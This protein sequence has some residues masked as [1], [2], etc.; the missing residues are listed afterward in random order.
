MFKKILVANR[1]AI[2]VRILRTCRD[3]GIP[4]VSIYEPEDLYSLHVRLADECLALESPA[5]YL[6]APAILALAQQSGADAIHPGYGYLGEQAGFGQACL[7]AGITL[8]GPSP[9]RLAHL[10]NRWNILRQAGSLGYLTPTVSS[11]SFPLENDEPILDEANR[12]GFPV[13]IKSCSGG[14]GRSAWLVNSPDQLQKTVQRAR[15]DL[16][17]WEGE[18]QFFLEQAI[19]PVHQVR[20]Q[21]LGDHYGNRVHL[22]ERDGS[23]QY[24]SQ[25]LIEESPSPCLERG[26]RADLMALALEL[27]HQFGVDSAETVEFLVD[28]HGRFFFTEIKPSIQVGHPVTEMVSGIDLVAEQTRIAAGEPLRLRQEEIQIRGWA[29]QCRINAVDPLRS[30][31]P[32]PGVLRHV[33]WPGGAN[34]RVDTYVSCGYEISPQYDPALAKVITWGWSRLECLQRMRRAL[35]ET[36]LNGVSTDLPLHQHILHSQAFEHGEYSTSFLMSL[37]EQD[38]SLLFAGEDGLQISDMAIA[39]S[40]LYLRRTMAFN[41]MVPDRLKTGWHQSL[42]R[43]N[44]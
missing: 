26:G 33:R 32:S 10:S 1:G 35:K 2:A 4:T 22:G 16:A 15:R 37:F 6:N 27:A 18:N 34:V 19:L 11:C 25:K 30:F 17:W 28:P 40:I 38:S 42:R 3:L 12:L 21:V 23:I 14:L 8:I 41:P 13:V 24:G 7:A 43:F 5:S 29:M 39:A 9:V 36:S 31:L 20:V 44:R